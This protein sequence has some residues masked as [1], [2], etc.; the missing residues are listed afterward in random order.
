MRAACIQ[1][2]VDLCR[3][4][5][6]TKRA[7]ELA[8]SA[9]EM[10]ADIL[11]FPELFLTGFCYDPSAQDHPPYPSLEPFR[12]LAR[13]RSCIIIGSIISGEYNLGFCL[14]PGE[15]QFRPKIHPFDQEKAHFKGGDFIAP[16]I[17]TRGN[18][19]LEVC[20]DLRFP[21][22]A[23]S[24]ALQGA[25][26][27]V[28]VAQFP[29]T[30]RVHWR[31]LCSARAMENQMPH[32]ACNWAEGGNSMIIDARGEVVAEAGQFEDV[33]VEEIDLAGRDQFRREVTCFRDRRPE[34]Y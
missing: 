34:V 21:E 32:I 9:L 26:L 14:D 4:E 15:I 8:E 7:L 24:L 2:Q 22:V 31:T 19:G 1:L 20:Y 23:R 18:I 17:T 28:T 13:E 27:L 33:I 16:V 11:V 10:G 12:T 6:N 3:R 29:S 5:D 30:R 25:D